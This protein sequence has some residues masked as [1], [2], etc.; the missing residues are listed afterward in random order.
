MTRRNVAFVTYE[1]RLALTFDD[2]LAAESLRETADIH[3][4]A[5]PW[6][7]PAV[8]WESF[9]AVVLRSTWD[10]FRRPKEFIDW[11]QDLERRRA[12]VFN[13]PALAIWNAEKTYLRDL[14]ATVP[15]VPTVWVERGE[16]VNL[17]RVLR[18]AN[19]QTAVVKPTVSGTAYKTWV[20]SQAHPVCFRPSSE[21]HTTPNSEACSR[22]WA[23]SAL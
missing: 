8:P 17:E 21:S 23:T 2:T 10:Y 3:V 13:A 15:I 18:E 7:R 4:V 6:D 14:A 22:Q 11:L 9:D 5:I 1:G 20:I 16:Q 12:R 19:W